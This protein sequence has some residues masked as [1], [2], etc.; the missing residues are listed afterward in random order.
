M[1]ETT[2]KKCKSKLLD[3]SAWGLPS[4]EI[5]KL[6]GRLVE[7][8]ERFASCFE[9]QTRDTSYYAL[10]ILSGL[11]RMTIERNFTN[12]A[13]VAGQSPQNIQHFMSHSPW[14]GPEVLGEIRSE[15]GQ[16]E[17]FSLAAP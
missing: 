12:L 10:D 15:I 14:E 7:F 17:R 4:E 11:L 6:S 5:E 1:C 16:I 2:E 3:P 13:R 8:W 9:T